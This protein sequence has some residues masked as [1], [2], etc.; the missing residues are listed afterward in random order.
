M[1]KFKFLLGALLLASTSV[2]TSCFSNDIPSIVING[3][4]GGTPGTGTVKL[5][6]ITQSSNYTYTIVCNVAADIRVGKSY[7]D[8]QK[9]SSTMTYTGKGGIGEKIYIVASTTIPGYTTEQ[10]KKV[11]TLDSNGKV[12]TLTFAKNPSEATTADANHKYAISLDDALALTADGSVISIENTDANKFEPYPKNKTDIRMYISNKMTSNA[13]GAGTPGSA[14][15]T[16][17]GKPAVMT[18]VNQNVDEV[19]E[20]FPV[21]GLK[22][23]PDG[24]KFGDDNPAVVV[25]TNKDFERD[26][27]F[28]CRSVDPDKNE[29][30]AASKA[31]NGGSVTVKFS[32]FSDYV[33]ES[34]VRVVRTD[35]TEKI[36][37]KSLLDCKIG[38]L[39]YKYFV[40]S[41]CDYSY[42][43]NEFIN[44]Y[45]EAKFG[46]KRY[47]ATGELTIS[48]QYQRATVP[49]TVTQIKTKYRVYFGDLQIDVWV[50]GPEE[51]EV[52]EPVIY[53]PTKHS[54]GAAF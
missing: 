50:Y 12:I 2:L 54:G 26:M 43:S 41:G 4:Q 24:A 45:L 52:G 34:E 35:E 37:T 9:V 44:N 27:T 3:Q 8:V 22:C 51:V 16:I 20:W 18:D 31:P 39:T 48:N 15:Y 28:R 29:K 5:G 32:H 33:V 21:L 38:N 53:D 13:L 14:L 42:K 10:I 46:K 7:S 30:I 19:L 17:T 1:K 25:V 23:C 36:E 49:Y 40:Y 6:E 47:E 11:V